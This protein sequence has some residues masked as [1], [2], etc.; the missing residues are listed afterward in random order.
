MIYGI[1]IDLIEIKRIKNLQNQ[2]KFIER[3]LTI[4]ERD[5]LNQYT[6]EQLRYWVGEISIVSGY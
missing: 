1:G 3:I 6:H 4:E 5:K 2:T